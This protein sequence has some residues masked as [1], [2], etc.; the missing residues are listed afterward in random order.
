MGTGL[1]SVYINMDQW[2]HQWLV[3]AATHA[4][5]LGSYVGIVGILLVSGLGLPIPEDIPL[6]VAGLLCG[7]GLANIWVMLPLC[8]VA[9]FG[10][11]MMVYA[12]GRVYGHHVPRMPIVRRYLTPNRLAGAE[13]AFHRH[14]GKTLFVARFLPGFRSAIYF[15]A[16]TFK[17]SVWKMVLFDG[18]ASLLSVPALVLMGYFGTKHFAAI[19]SF[20]ER[21]QLGLLVV[22]ALAVAGGVMWRLRRRRGAAASAGM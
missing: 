3:N 8:L 22:F 4:G 12:L 21:T 16:G 5:S 14:G 17:I 2:L 13:R 10:A 18:L 20:V 9:V 11:D 6:L 15:T 19:Q 1:R 7:L